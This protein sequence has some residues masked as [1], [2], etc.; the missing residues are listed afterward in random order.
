LISIRIEQL[1]V[2]EQMTLFQQRI[3]CRRLLRSFNH[4]GDKTDY[5]GNIN[6]QNKSIQEAK[7][8]KLDQAL[9]HY[10][11][12][13]LDYECC[14][15]NE[16]SNLEAQLWIQHHFETRHYYDGM[17]QCLQEYLNHRQHRTLRTIRYQEA[18]V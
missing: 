10:E 5:T 6:I 11:R 3:L 12:K 2:F 18:R 17:V 7:R 8:R 9:E 1:K 16:L 14:Y 13:L 4:T 15:Q